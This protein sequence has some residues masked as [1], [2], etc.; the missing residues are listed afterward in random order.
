MRISLLAATLLLGAM[1]ASVRP[2]IAQPSPI[3][4]EQPWARATS[5]AAKAGGVF[6]TIKDNGPAD[7]L[8]G[9]SSPVAGIVELHRTV[10][11]NGVMKMLPVPVLDLPTGQTIDLKPGGLH[12]MLIDLRRQLKPGDTFPL[13]LTFAK[14]PPATVTVTVGAAGASGP[15]H[16]AMQHGGH[17][18]PKP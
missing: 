6:M 10:N 16:G 15:A 12:I 3:K 13:T 1:P 7:Q 5:S 4:I 18:V 2:A 9:A 17:V 11:E 8:V 14:A